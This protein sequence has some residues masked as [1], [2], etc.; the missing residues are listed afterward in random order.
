[1]GY[2]LILLKV[3]RLERAR[4]TARNV[5]NE[6]LLFICV[7]PQVN[8]VGLVEKTHEDAVSAFRGIKGTARLEVEQNAERKVLNV[9]FNIL[10]I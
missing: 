5:R 4:L 1:M 3:G 8:G 6:Q 2:S 10:I 7:F 9:G